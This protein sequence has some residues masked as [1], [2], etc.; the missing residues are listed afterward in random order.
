MK[1]GA[2]ARLGRCCSTSVWSYGW[3]YNNNCKIVPCRGL[4]IQ[5]PDLTCCNFAMVRRPEDHWVAFLW[6]QRYVNVEFEMSK[7][8]NNDP[9]VQLH[10]F[11]SKID[12]IILSSEVECDVCVYVDVGICKRWPTNMVE[13]LQ[14]YGW[15]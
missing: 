15:K 13:A 14:F 9:R 8:N 6:G 5:V 10:L 2:I 11:S 7:L 12:K 1:I 4:A 3:G